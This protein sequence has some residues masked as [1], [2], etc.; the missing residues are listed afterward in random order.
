MPDGWRLSGDRGDWAGLRCW[1]LSLAGCWLNC[2]VYGRDC[3]PAKDDHNNNNK[4]APFA[5]EVAQA[6]WHRS[7]SLT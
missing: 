5:D 6:L 4:D 7:D 3:K 1:C 2:L